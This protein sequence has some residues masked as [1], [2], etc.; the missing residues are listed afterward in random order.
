MGGDR[1]LGAPRPALRRRTQAAAA[2]VR[3]MPRRPLAIPASMA[4][5]EKPWSPNSTP[6]TAAAGAPSRPL[7]VRDA[8]PGD[9]RLLTNHD[10]QPGDG[11]DTGVRMTHTSSRSQG[12][13]IQPQ[14]DPDHL[15]GRRP[16]HGGLGDGN[17]PV[18]ASCGGGAAP[19]GS[20]RDHHVAAVE[21]LASYAGGRH[22]RPGVPHH[23]DRVLEQLREGGF[24]SALLLLRLAEPRPVVV[25]PATRFLV[26]AIFAVPA[27]TAPPP[28]RRRAS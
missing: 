21:L 12:T 27:E 11:L 6:A 20:G 25:A 7:A 22:V 18:A 19:L 10:G 17:G 2:T 14:R 4:A 23:L 16:S 5:A 9:D 26:L 1:H 28:T 15:R 8:G 3:T 13:L 24:C